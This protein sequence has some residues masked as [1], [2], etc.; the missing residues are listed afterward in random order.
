MQS[1]AQLVDNFVL[2]GRIAPDE[3]MRRLLR[4]LGS[5]SSRVEH[6]HLDFKREFDQSDSQWLDF[7]KHAVALANT[8]GGVLVLGVSDDGT[9]TGLAESLLQVF[10]PT[11]VASRITKYSGNSAVRT[12]YS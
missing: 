7:V 5:N 8:G 9:R 11:K 3:E 10:D 2:D 1:A 4:E 12:A 6:N